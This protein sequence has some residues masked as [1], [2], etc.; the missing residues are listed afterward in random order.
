[1]ET[2]KKRIRRVFNP[3]TLTCSIEP[4]ATGAQVAQV[5]FADNAEY[6]PNRE[7]ILGLATILTP[8]VT[9]F[10]KDD[11][12]Q[13][14]QSNAR[15]GRFDWLVNG[16]PIADVWPEGSFSIDTTPT[17]SRG[18][19]TI[20]HNIPADTQVSLTFEAQITDPRTNVTYSVVSNAIVLYTS[21]AVE[22][23]KSITVSR[24]LVEYD[25]FLDFLLE[26]N[27]CI[28]NGITPDMSEADAMSQGTPHI[29]QVSYTC[30]AGKNSIPAT[31]VTLQQFNGE[32]FVDASENIAL[33]HD[34]AS[35]TVTFDVRL[36]PDNT[37]FRLLYEP[38]DRNVRYADFSVVRRY[39]AFDV[40]YVNIGNVADS[41]TVRLI[42][43]VVTTKGTTS[44]ILP[45]PE[46]QMVMQWLSDS[47]TK[48]KTP[49]NQG[50]HGRIDII[51][52]GMGTQKADGWLDVYMDISHRQ[53]AV[54]TSEK[55]EII[56]DNNNRYI[57]T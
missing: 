18:T 56:V 7:G 41:E 42:D 51:K 25:T 24:D 50:E 23:E 34:R 22:S 10:C 52:A 14:G 28:V 43:A 11:D 29:Q 38:D 35:Q 13:G 57:I 3:L 49:H 36:L 30:Y 54:I 1:M 33:I 9:T 26:R 12:W 31:N 4:L 45:H 47:S 21:T 16:K 6:I 5:Y 55:G 40:S 20:R 37:R 2:S 27:W 46:A 53:W 19:L 48:S 44:R 15:L 17:A 8:T 39:S 32:E